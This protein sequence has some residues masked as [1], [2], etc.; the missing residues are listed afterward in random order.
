MSKNFNVHTERYNLGMQIFTKCGIIA[1]SYK[2]DYLIQPSAE[3]GASLFYT[4]VFS[5]TLYDTRMRSSL[6]HALNGPLLMKA[7]AYY[8]RKQR[9]EYAF[10][11]RATI[12]F[13]S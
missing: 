4:T 5:L 7:F 2:Q 10:C 6:A 1:V 8:R 3:S 13:A 11:N 9:S 12:R